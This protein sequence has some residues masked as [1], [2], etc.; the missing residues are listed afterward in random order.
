LPPEETFS[1]QDTLPLLVRLP[2]RANS[3]TEGH[4]PWRNASTNSSAICPNGHD[5]HHLVEHL[6]VR[7][8]AVPAYVSIL[9]MSDERFEEVYATW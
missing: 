5:A 4:W 3:S 2:R 7:R 1:I 6:A 9:D 8:N